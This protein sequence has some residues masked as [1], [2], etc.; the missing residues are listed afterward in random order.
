[1]GGAGV[2]DL[3]VMLGR[4]LRN[5]CIVAAAIAAILWVVW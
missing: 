5:L 1:M 4:W 2:A 3:V